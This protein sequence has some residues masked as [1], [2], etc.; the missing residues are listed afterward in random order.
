MTD[1]SPLAEAQLKYAEAIPSASMASETVILI[2][3][4]GRTLAQD[5][6]APEDSPP[7]NR[8]IVEGFLVNTAETQS[9]SEENPI[10]VQVIGHVNPGDE[11][12]PSFGEG[13]AIEV[14]T[15][16]ILPDGQVSIVR[17]WEAKRDGDTV[18]VSRPFPPRFFIEEQGCDITKDSTL[19]KAGHVLTP[20]DLANI[21][22]L[23]VNE[24]SVACA[25]K[26]AIF[27]SGDE[28]IAHTDT[29]RSGS[30]RDCNSIQLAAA[31]TETGG[32]AE[33]KGIMGDDFDA[34][35]KAVKA[36]LKSTD[37]IIIAG[38]TAV[39]GR[40]FVSDLIKEVGELV[41]DGVPM[42]S[43]RPLIMGVTNGKPIIAVAGHPPEAL[44]GFRLFGATA[45]A[46]L[47]GRD[48]DPAIEG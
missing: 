10:S 44:R 41:I 13:Q 37:M 17:M 11:S 32:I 45:L 7:Y 16:S 33:Q 2:D 12:C 1:Q 40:D 47:L 24:I 9:A 46:K 39:G 30:I 29:L 27:A 3:A 8:A 6:N 26:V 43:G 35:V 15:G 38:G 14:N 36:S 23:G 48:I 31:V 34:F 25:P 22:S 18:T 19:L 20:A 4:L 42:R 21:A 28:V 5:F